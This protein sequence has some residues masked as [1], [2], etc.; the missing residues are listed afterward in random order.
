M[1]KV[2]TA[3]VCAIISSGVIADTRMNEG[4]SYV[5]V[6]VSDSHVKLGQIAR[7]TATHI[8]SLHNPYNGNMPFTYNY[9]LKV[10]GQ[11]QDHTDYVTLAPFERR[12]LE[13]TSTMDVAFNRGTYPIVA[14]SATN[15]TGR[16]CHRATLKVL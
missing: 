10:N 16:T 14:C 15:Q 11:A 4:D 1:K 12:N 7:V 5:D 2:I 8:F 6:N 13:I 3:I 9:Q